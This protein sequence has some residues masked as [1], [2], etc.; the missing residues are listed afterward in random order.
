MTLSADAIGQELSFGEDVEGLVDLPIKEIIDRLKA[1]F[2]ETQEKAG[3]LVICG[4][5]GPID[6][7]WSWQFL[8]IEASQLDDDVKQKFIALGRSFDCEPYETQS[9]FP[10]S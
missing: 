4:Q 5:G 8:R 10:L 9:T 7:S 6:V 1:E 2:P 3:L